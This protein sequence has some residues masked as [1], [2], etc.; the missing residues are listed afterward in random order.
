MSILDILIGV[1]LGAICAITFFSSKIDYALEITKAIE[2]CEQSL[3]RD[4][5]CV[6]T[7]IPKE[8]ANE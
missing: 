7:A 2:I 5:Q 6:I 3:P 1:C 4:E 8:I